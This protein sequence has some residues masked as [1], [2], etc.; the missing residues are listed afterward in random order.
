MSNFPTVVASPLYWTLIFRTE[1]NHITQTTIHNGG[2][3]TRLYYWGPCHVVTLTNGAPT[4]AQCAANLRIQNW[5]SIGDSYSNLVGSG[6]QDFRNLMSSDPCLQ[7]KQPQYL[8]NPDASISFIADQEVPKLLRNTNYV[9]MTAGTIDIGLIQILDA[10]VYNFIGSNAIDCTQLIAKAASYIASPAFASS[11][12]NVITKT[13]SVLGPNSGKLHVVGNAA[14]FAETT[15]SCNQKS[16]AV[17]VGEGQKKY[18]ST[19]VRKQLNE[20]IHRLNWW[21]NYLVTKYNQAQTGIIRQ[22]P[23]QYI[24]YDDRFN[25]HRLC[26]AD[27]DGTG[28]GVAGTW[29]VDGEGLKTPITRAPYQSLKPPATCNPNGGWNEYATCR[30]AKCIQKTSYLTLT[31]S[32]SGTALNNWERIMHPT[33]AGH[34]AIRDEIVSQIAQGPT[35]SGHNLRILPLG[36]SITQ[37]FA[38]SDNLGYR[39]TL[40]DTLRK[41]NTVAYV[42]SQGTSPLLHEG[43]PGWIIKDVDTVAGVSLPKRPNVVLIHVGTNDI[44]TNNNVDQAPDRIG[45]LIDH[46]TSV[47]PDAVVLV[48]TLVS[49]RPGAFDKLV[50]FNA[51]IASIVNLRQGAGKK[52]MKVSMPITTDDLIDGVHPN[53]AGY[54]KMSEGWIMGLQRAAGRGWIESGNSTSPNAAM[55]S[56][57]KT[58]ALSIGSLPWLDQENQQVA[59]FSA[60]ETDDFAFSVRNELDF[61]NEHMADI[62]S[63]N[64][65]NITEVFK[66]PG[67]LRG[68]TPRTARKR[69]PLEIREP[70][71]DIFAPNAKPVPSPTRNP[72]PPR[73]P[74]R[75]EVAHDAVLNGM[76]KNTKTS[77]DS[78]YHGMTEDE[79]DVDERGTVPLSELSQPKKQALSVPVDATRTRMSREQSAFDVSFHSA[80]EEIARES[81][82]EAPEA[83]PHTDNSPKALKPLTHAA[84]MNVLSLEPQQTEPSK[85]SAVENEAGEKE[86]VLGEEAVDDSVRSASAGSSPAIKGLVRKSSLTFAALPAREPLTTK[87]SIGARVSRISHVD[88]S[89]GLM[90]R[91]SFLGKLTGD[92]SLGGSC[93]PEVES[94]TL[95]ND[96]M[97]LDARERPPATREESDQETKV[98]RLH[99]KSSTQ[100]LHDRINMLGK[101]Q[102]ARPTKS[103]PAT[104]TLTQPPYPDLALDPALRNNAEQSANVNEEDD[105]WIK[106]PPTRVVDS[107]RPM[108]SKSISTDVM[109]N[110]RGKINISDREFGND[111][112]GSRPSP[113]RHSLPRDSD[114]GSPNTAFLTRPAPADQVIRSTT[115]TETPTSQRYADGPLSASKSKLQSIMKTARG[116]FTSS[117]G[118]SAQAKMELQ[119]QTQAGA[120]FNPSPKKALGAQDDTSL[121]LSLGT[122]EKML[123]SFTDHPVN[124]AKPVEGRKTRGSIEKEKK[125]RERQQ[126]NDHPEKLAEVTASETPASMQ[127]PASEIEDHRAEVNRFDGLDEFPTTRSD[128]P[129]TM[130]EQATR[131][132]PRRMEKQQEATIDLKA[133]EEEV[134]DHMATT[135]NQSQP[136]SNQSQLQRPNTKRP[137][138]PA[139]EPAP[140]PEPQRVAI[141]VGTLSQRI[142]LTNAA[143]SSGL[144]DSLPPPSSKRPGL[145]KKTSTTSMQT[146]ASNNSFRNTAN[147]KP[148]ALIAAER[149]KEQDEKEAQRKLEQKRDIERKRAAQQ[150]ETRRHEQTQRQEADRPRERERAAAADDPKKLAQRQAIEMRRQGLAKKEPQRTAS[151]SQHPAPANLRPELGGARPVSKMQTAQDFS[152]PVPNQVKAPIK[153]VLEPEADEPV[154]QSRLPGGQQYQST[155]AK[156]RRTDDETSEEPSV[157]PTMAPPKRQSNLLKDVQRP[158][159]PSL[160]GPP[161]SIANGY[162][163]AKPTIPSHPYQPQYQQHSGQ[164]QRP[165]QAP[166]MAKYAN[167]RIVFAENTNAAHPHHKTPNQSRLT[168]QAHAKSSPQYVNGENIHLEDIPTD[169]DEDDSDR[170]EDKKAK[171]AMLPS[172]VQSPMLNNLLREQEK[173]KD[174][175]SIFGPSAAVNM[176]EMFKE[177]HHR[178]RSRT[179]SANWAGNDR[180]TDEEIR[181]DNAARERMRREGG[182]TFG[183]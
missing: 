7:G 182:W 121:Y 180:L 39:K 3:F 70:L 91:G 129:P 1:S 79:M 106:P 40:Y 119:N 166:D 176:E 71:N 118:A 27:V 25:G 139:K 9:T 113:R 86:S 56:K 136:A 169:S 73:E 51:R 26:R 49:S 34:D 132:S 92:K 44:L 94:E 14:F 88:A 72:K 162:S 60:Q 98:A 155:D 144:Q 12:N 37:G 28:S 65:M 123:P 148:K 95:D 68:K 159:G 81:S 55:A 47:A 32:G 128:Q 78:G 19:T 17:Y 87:K 96:H 85:D 138:K 35:L 52:V 108:L 125:Q 5:A 142:P 15:P 50:T 152:R 161:S 107:P 33:S 109:E 30:M 61:L 179:S 141:R 102:P 183:L 13:R 181:S 84:D 158:Y 36:A 101:S 42:G 111:Q 90:S 31:K 131:K 97:D 48:S 23:V 11:W 122:D 130:K 135:N 147:S 75:F 178:F 167:G 99:N 168:N 43:H 2:N 66:T 110:L 64:Q 100:R 83:P 22:Y 160:M 164:I 54:K 41:T 46:V 45:A 153:R 173:N 69:N 163:H 149:K 154:R 134:V 120:P 143:I 124:A 18:L 16:L 53:D 82:K 74:P 80:T 6:A 89:K 126:A 57:T 114:T 77:H 104:A 151:A 8:A 174:A 145:S 63:K 38:S 115:P 58:V 21:Q 157:R 177:R 76:D 59:Q 175:D 170:E 20:L 133:T 24:D 62:F 112:H 117:A 171:G 127:E 156:R 103:I 172:W 116:L 137:I 4:S 140:K 150:E 165:G 146:A 105:D 29:F 93:Q 10:C 67:K